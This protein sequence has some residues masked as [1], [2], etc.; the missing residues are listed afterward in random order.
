MAA[1][2]CLLQARKLA[3]AELGGLEKDHY[4]CNCDNGKI[5]VSFSTFGSTKP[6]TVTE[7]TCFSCKGTG[8]TSLNGYISRFIGCK[9][10]HDT[11]DTYA[12]FH[13]SDGHAVFGNDTYICARCGMVT[14]FG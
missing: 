14:Q 11:I 9:C 3:M 2:N 12:S 4:P 13:A 8:F 6:A 10:N 5:K 7:M 1:N